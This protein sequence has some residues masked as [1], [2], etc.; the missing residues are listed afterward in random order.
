ATR[1]TTTPTGTP[2]LRPTSENT[3]LKPG[4]TTASH[5][6]HILAKIQARSRVQAVTYA[7]E[8]GLVQPAA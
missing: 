3:V 4:K 1:Q 5:V 8:S 6:S 7:Y 2:T